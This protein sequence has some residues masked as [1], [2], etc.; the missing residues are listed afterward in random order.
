[1][2]RFLH[3]ILPI[4]C[5][6]LLQSACQ[7][8]SGAFESDDADKE[9]LKGKRISVLKHRSQLIADEKEKHVYVQTPA[10]VENK[11]WT[12]QNI[13]P[14]N[15][16]ALN[17][18]ITDHLTTSVGNSSDEVT[19]LTSTPIVAQGKI[20]TL[21]ANGFV[22]ARDANNLEKELWSF[23]IGQDDID[24]DI[25]GL[26]I[27][28][29]KGSKEY[30]GGNI[31]YG[32]GLLYIT[33][34]RAKVIALNAG[35]GSVSWARTVK[36]PVKSPPVYY[37]EKLYLV[38]ASN[39]LFAL[40]A[41]DG[42][43]LWTHSGL[44]EETSIYGSSSP[45]A[46]SDAGGDIVIV[47]YSSGELYALDA[48]NGSQI[49][50]RLMHNNATSLSSLLSLSDID[51][52]PVISNGIVYAVGY[53]SN[54]TAIELRSGKTIWSE[55]I[56]GTKT[57]WVGDK[58]LYIL[59]ANNELVCVDAFN[60]TIK[61]VQQLLSNE[62]ASKWNILSDDAGERI[63]WNGPVLA[64]DNLIIVGSHGKMAF[65][66]PYSGKIIGVSNIETDVSLPPIVAGKKI[67]LLSN[68]G[69]LSAFW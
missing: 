3:I 4:I 63:L 59:T 58:F 39:T 23:T 32:G 19:R 54:L 2:Q 5:V 20:F 22:S 68:N 41:K 64:Q 50:G 37:K 28:I 61:W 36:L 21:D 47:P 52:T 13:F 16:L 57:P 60:G 33:T 55:D 12:Q 24:N 56:T 44:Q 6:I 67:Y 17:K 46:A 42:Q 18:K 65:A 51:A 43:T 30:L 9:P 45:V 10:F 66:N 31:S 49:W 15:H 7:T 35:D 53:E 11:N 27:V 38:T 8:I 29:G 40:S 69:Q 48:K 62:K 25:F 14:A 26:G 1:M 34:E